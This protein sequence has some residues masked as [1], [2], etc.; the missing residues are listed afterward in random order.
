MSLPS[1]WPRLLVLG[2][3]AV[4]AAATLL[5]AA[6]LAQEPQMGGS[7]VAVI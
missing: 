4:V 5:P 3:T 7:I 2:T 1:P 6:A